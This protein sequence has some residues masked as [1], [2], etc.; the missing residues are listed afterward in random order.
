MVGGAVV[1]V[2]IDVVVKRVELVKKS[3]VRVV[4]V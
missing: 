2:V 4:E 3:V 1:V